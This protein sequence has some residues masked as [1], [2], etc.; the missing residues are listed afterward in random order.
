MVAWLFIDIML[1]YILILFNIK[2]NCSL[3]LDVIEPSNKDIKVA[4]SAFQLGDWIPGTN[5]SEILDHWKFN[6]SF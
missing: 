5:I 2:L 6:L 4:Y 1:F 3:A